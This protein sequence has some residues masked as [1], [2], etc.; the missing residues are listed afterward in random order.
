MRS[1]PRFS[2]RCRDNPRDPAHGKYPPSI[3]QRGRCDQIPTLPCF[4]KCSSSPPKHMCTAHP[5][6]PCSQLFQ[7]IQSSRAAGSFVARRRRRGEI[8]RG[9]LC[10]YVDTR[11]QKEHGGGRHMSARA[12]PQ[13]RSGEEWLCGTEGVVLGCR[14]LRGVT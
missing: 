10:G 8:W 5:T 12:D 7:P 13:K 4:S 1:C 11:K 2:L 3:L 9:T 14:I 6:L